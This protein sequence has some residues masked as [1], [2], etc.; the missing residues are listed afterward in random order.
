MYQIYV[1]G[2]GQTWLF[3]DYTGGTQRDAQKC[4]EIMLNFL[5]INFEDL[6]MMHLLYEI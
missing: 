3:D 1:K 4:S 6:N 2:H 5:Q